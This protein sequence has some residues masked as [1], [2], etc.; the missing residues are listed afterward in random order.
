MA[1]K[2]L[3]V[4]MGSSLLLSIII[5]V[6]VIFSG[7]VIR[8]EYSEAD[9]EAVSSMNSVSEYDEGDIMSFLKEKFPKLSTIQAEIG[10][11]KVYGYNIQYTDVDQ[12]ANNEAVLTGYFG[13]PA[14]ILKK[15]GGN[16]KVLYYNDAVY[17][18]D[19]KKDSYGNLCFNFSFTDSAG[20]GYY[21]EVILRWDGEILK[22]IW[23]G[24]TDYYRVVLRDNGEE[25]R[26]NSAI[27]EI[28]GTDK[29]ELKYIVIEASGIVD[30]LEEK[31]TNERTTVKRYAFDEDDF[32]FVEK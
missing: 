15:R 6:V 20:A 24:V 30:G 5:A 25:W 1:K 21:E 28:T 4:S 13:V 7:P 27:Y 12:D 16:F 9:I 31:V 3:L 14:V 10:E 2:K 32:K 26:K 22:E 18:S 11:L 17:K 29:M 8:I 19:F 23:R